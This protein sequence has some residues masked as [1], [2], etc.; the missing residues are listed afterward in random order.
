M[1]NAWPDALRLIHRDRAQPLGYNIHYMKITFR[2][3]ELGASAQ[4]NAR[5]L[6][7][8]HVLSGYSAKNIGQWFDLHGWKF[9]K[10]GVRV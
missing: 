7:S 4:F 9:D 1:A 5:C 2:F 8:F 10:D 6:Y 3:S